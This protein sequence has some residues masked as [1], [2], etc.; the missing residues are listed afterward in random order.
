MNKA[1]GVTRIIKATGY[2]LKGLKQAWQHEAAFRQELMLLVVAVLVACWLPVAL[3]ER[4]L[5]IGVVVVVV[6]MELVNSAI[7]AV[8][9]RVGTE[10][11]ELSGRA[12]D[13]GSAA[14]FVALV[15][16]GIVWVSILWPLILG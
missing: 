11:H 8:V 2:S 15:F 1:T 4:L 16:A 14:V 3:L 12:K 5:L 10:H 13:I 7:E 9:D 6:L